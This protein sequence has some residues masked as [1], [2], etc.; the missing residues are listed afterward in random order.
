MRRLPHRRA[1]YKEDE[2]TNTHQKIPILSFMD[3]VMALKQSRGCEI[4][5]S[6][7]TPCR[8]LFIAILSFI[9]KSLQHGRYDRDRLG[10]YKLPLVMLLVAEK[11][12]NFV[13]IDR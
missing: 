6:P 9:F 11:G 2:K 3:T 8:T 13:N 12:K 4:E 10:G 7:T 1:R 5:S